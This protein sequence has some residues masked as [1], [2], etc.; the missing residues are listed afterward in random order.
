MI[1]TVT[2]TETAA[3]YINVR[4]LGELI[5]FHPDSLEAMRRRGGGPPF[6]RIGDGPR[7][8]IRYNLD[9]VEQWLRKHTVGGAS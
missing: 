8:A 4:Q 3:K 6:V 7:A 5:G 2:T 1:K 9:D